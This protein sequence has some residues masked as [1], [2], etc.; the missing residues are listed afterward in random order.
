[1]SVRRPHVLTSQ[2]LVVRRFSRRWSSRRV[3]DAR[4]RSASRQSSAR[5]RRILRHRHA[6]S[7]YFSA[8]SAHERV[9]EKHG[10]RGR[11]QL[12]K[13]VEEPRDLANRRAAFGGCPP[14]HARR[15]RD[16]LRRR[17]SADEGC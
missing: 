9:R 10:S 11:L 13:E 8:V 16:Q 5:D 12:R 4:T 2:W 14:P 1:V 7:P 17:V 6:F 3:S 15:L